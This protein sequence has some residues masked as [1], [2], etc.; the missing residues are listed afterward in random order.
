[1]CI[2]V[3]YIKYQ[4]QAYFNQIATHLE[5]ELQQARFSV[6]LAVA[7]LNHP[8]LIYSLCQAAERGVTVEVIISRDDNNFNKPRKVRQLY[9]LLDAGAMVMVSGPEHGLADGFFHHKFCVIDYDT[10][11]TGSFNWTKNATTNEE[12]ILITRGEQRLGRQYQDTFEALLHHSHFL[13]EVLHR[14]VISFDGTDAPA[15]ALYLWASEAVA[16]PGGAVTL[17]WRAIHVEDLA[18]IDLP[19]GAPIPPFPLPGSGHY[20]FPFPEYEH[21]ATLLAFSLEGEQLRSQV[22]LR[23]ARLPQIESFALSHPVTVG[24]T[25]PVELSWKVT[26]VEQII[27]T[28]DVG[29]TDYPLEGSVMVCPLSST[30]YTITAVGLGGQQQASA[31]LLVAGVPQ[32]KRLDIPVPVNLRIQAELRY[33]QTPVPSGLDLTTTKIPTLRL[34]SVTQLSAELLPAT[35]T[36]AEL[37][38]GLGLDSPGDLKVPP[39]P[40]SASTSWQRTKSRI[41]TKLQQQF[42]HDWRMTHLLSTF[43]N[44]YGD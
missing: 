41:L 13:I 28:P 40:P 5:H 21:T 23:P 31:S 37:T 30:T 35:P 19:P 14:P 38:T 42:A 9:D 44:L 20:T 16:A 18:L 1:M 26:Q 36:L 7:W 17:H 2:S 12:N 29:L 10:V 6:R 43:R 15:S 39:R 24:G 27:I 3:K 33:S 34:P 8:G 32:L 4:S 25:I 22:R 11:I